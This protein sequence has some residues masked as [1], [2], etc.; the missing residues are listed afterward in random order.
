MFLAACC[1]KSMIKAR[2]G[3]LRRVE[4]TN[5]R[6]LFASALAL[7][8]SAGAYFAVAELS[9]SALVHAQSVNQEAIS[10]IVVEGNQ[11]IETRTILSYLLVEPGDNFDSERLDLSLKTLFATQLFADVLFEKNGS[12]LVVR[13]SENPI[14]N[15]VIFEGNSSIRDDKLTE[16]TEAAPREVFTQARVQQ[17][18]QKILEA[19]RRAGRFA[20]SVTPTYKPLAQNRVDLIFE[21]TEGPKTGVKSINFIGNE[22]F[23]DSKLRSEVVT[24]QSRW[25]RVFES[26]DNFDPD[27]MEYDRELLR[28][29]YTNEG[30]ADFRVTSSIAELTPDQKDFYM[31]FTI[32]EGPLY[33]FGEISVETTLEKLSTVR[34]K[35]I[36]PTREGNLYKAD[37]IEDAVEAIT[38]A[39]GSA[40]YASVD[41]KPQIDR[42]PETQKVNVTFVVDEGPRVYVERLDIVGNTQTLDHVVRRELLL[43]EGDAFNRILLDQSRNRIRSLGFFKDVEITEEPGSAPDKTIVKVAVQEQ[44]TGELAFSVGYS[45][46]DAFLVSVSATQRNFR[47]RGQSVTANIQSSQY[48]ENYE[49]RFTEPRF[50]DRNMAA[51]FD[52]Y[53]NK[54]NYLNIANYSNSV[55][56]AGLRVGFPLGNRTQLGL[57]YNLRQDDLQLAQTNSDG[58]RSTIESREQCLLTN[59]ISICDQLGEQLTSSVGY[60]LVRDHRNDPIDPTGGYRITWQQDFAGL[61]GD[62]NYVKQEL[63]ASTYKGIAPGFT[64]TAGVKAGYIDGWNDDS[65]RVNNRFYKGGNT[66]RGFDTA[67]LGPRQ[68]NVVSDLVVENYAGAPAD[69]DGQLIYYSGISSSTGLPV[70]T[71]VNT[72]NLSEAVLNENGVLVAAVDGDGGERAYGSLATDGNGVTVEPQIRALGTALG[73]K[74]YAIGTV[75]LSIPI[76]FAPEEMG[77]GAALFTEFGSVG[78][79]D[80]IAKTGSNPTVETFGST[81]FA[82]S[83]TSIDDT[84]GLRASAGLSVFWDSPFGPI[85]FDFSEILAS[86]EYDRTESF[87][88]STRTQF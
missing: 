8:T 63:N 76:P 21:I 15:Q 29:F 70:G 27:R 38:F 17:D 86:E 81:G 12:E 77:I 50:Q 71:F 28:Q 4:D 19:Y 36:V 64:L 16:E 66:F 47:G 55:I 32:D 84:F 80:D 73:G 14:I 78:L 52:L 9:G 45:S 82:L 51:G 83:E 41:V 13:V 46:A 22:V 67:G 11:R 30:Y 68:T 43:A 62:V 2:Q 6:S 18:V 7:T 25:W 54:T 61:G 65:I 40:G 1:H 88:F 75:E 60:S 53:A 69:S 49:F 58:T 31:T 74:A 3:V 26:N 42:D 20:A 37:L 35:A 79:L 48:Q 44:P 39:A 24:R 10:H 87:R 56:G 5:M 85:R 33:N 72:G 34:L 57:R 23:K 59:S